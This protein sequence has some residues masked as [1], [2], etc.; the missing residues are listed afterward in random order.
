[1]TR[2]QEIEKAAYNVLQC[3]RDNDSLSAAFG[4]L[5][6]ALALPPDDEGYPGIAADF[7]NCRLE[8]DRLRA[9][10]RE[11]PEPVWR[12]GIL[13]MAQFADIYFEWYATHKDLLK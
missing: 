3:W 13:D 1:M 7:E 12:V 5:N 6:D 4:A 2:A 11:L 9:A 8:R 10:L